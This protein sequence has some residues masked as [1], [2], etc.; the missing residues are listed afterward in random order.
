MADPS[1]SAFRSEL[2]K[3]RLRILSE[4][5]HGLTR[6]V[7]ANRLRSV[8]KASPALRDS[9]DYT[10]LLNWTRQPVEPTTLTTEDLRA[11]APR[12]SVRY[13]RLTTAYLTTD[14]PHPTAPL[15]QTNSGRNRC[16]LCVRNNGCEGCGALPYDHLV[17]K[18]SFR[19]TLSAHLCNACGLTFRRTGTVLKRNRD[20]CTF[21]PAA[22]SKRKRSRPS[23]GPL[24]PRDRVLQDVGLLLHLFQTNGIDC[25]RTS[26]EDAVERVLIAS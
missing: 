16:D 26:F 7:V 22:Q 11:L 13:K 4:P 10:E 12:G 5:D 3:A 1:R 15:S 24:P 14:G 6:S 19:C 18:R 21:R 17:L 20:L 23:V 2:A 9:P 25:D 8:V